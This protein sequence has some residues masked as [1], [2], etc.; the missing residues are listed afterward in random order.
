MKKIAIALLL[1]TVTASA[2]AADVNYYVGV[3]GGRSS[4]NWPASSSSGTA[5]TLLGGVQLSE[6]FALEGQY[7]TLGSSSLASGKNAK[8]T[9][10]SLVAVG[11]MPFSNRWAGY[12]KFGDQITH[13]KFDAGAVSAGEYTAVRDTPT[14]GFGVQFNASSFLSLRL[15]YDIYG[16][17]DTSTGQVK[18]GVTSLGAIFRF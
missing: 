12:I 17:G 11:I 15:G 14:G 18:T 6:N 13:T 16:I 5:A 8:T 1:S 4:T 10:L 9:V 3:N 2:L 7:G